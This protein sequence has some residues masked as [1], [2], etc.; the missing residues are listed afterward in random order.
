MD[1]TVRDRSDHLVAKEV[2]PAVQA[3]E[4]PV[5]PG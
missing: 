1:A 4:L 5:G 3:V 2:L